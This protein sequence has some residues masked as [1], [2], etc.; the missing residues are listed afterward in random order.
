MQPFEDELHPERQLF[1]ARCARVFARDIGERGNAVQLAEV[2]GERLLVGDG[3]AIAV[4]EPRQDRFV[5]RLRGC[6]RLR[7]FALRLTREDL[8]STI[9]FQELMKF[10]VLRKV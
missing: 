2:I 5:R 6:C 1:F 7:L 8:D 10:N 9:T 4:G 3:D